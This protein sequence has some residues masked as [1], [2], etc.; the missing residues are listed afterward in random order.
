MKIL[1]GDNLI[2]IFEAPFKELE[3]RYGIEY[4][5]TITPILDCRSG[6]SFVEDDLRN[7]PMKEIVPTALSR[8]G[9]QLL[10]MFK[11]KAELDAAKS[12]L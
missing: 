5:C 10:R 4:G 3:K 9:P 2:S 8:R 11:T 6:G 1:Y 12:Q 7:K